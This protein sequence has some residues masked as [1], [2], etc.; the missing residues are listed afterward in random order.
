M[1]PFRE[2]NPVTI[3]FAGLLAIALML[4][5]AFRAE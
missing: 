5:A 2:R 1:K 4:R 3:G